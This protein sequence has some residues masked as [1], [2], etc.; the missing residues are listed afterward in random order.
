MKKNSLAYAALVA[1]AERV[2]VRM[3]RLASGETGIKLPLNVAA[4]VV[5][6]ERGFFSAS[7]V[8]DIADRIHKTFRGAAADAAV[9]RL[10]GLTEWSPEVEKIEF[11]RIAARLEFG[12]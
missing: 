6:V 12:S 1:D 7:A 4:A 9:D 11:V 8:S 2:V 10:Y 5:A 3:D